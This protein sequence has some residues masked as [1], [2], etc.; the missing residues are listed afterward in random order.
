MGNSEGEQLAVGIGAVIDDEKVLL[1]K[2]ESTSVKEYSD[3]WELPGGKIELDEWTEDAIER[4]VTEETGVCVKCSSLLPF[5]FSNTIQ[6][7]NTLTH[8]LVFCAKCEINGNKSSQEETDE[9]WYWFNFNEIEFNNIIPGSK[10]FLIWVLNEKG[11]KVP[12]DSRRYIIKLE[13][14]DSRENKKRGYNILLSFEPEEKRLYKVEKQWGR[15]GNKYDR[16][17]V[18]YEK[19]S[20][21]LG[22]VTKILKKRERNNYKIIHIS[23]NH[24]LRSWIGNSSIPKGRSE[25]PDLFGLNNTE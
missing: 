6:T 20:D 25:F 2:R 1:V 8:V 24:P 18:H 19:Y 7:D 11:Y 14:I 4:E 22:E 16:K 3:K 12:E 10:E 13:N 17:S 5:T 21:A 23:N 15:K 9:N